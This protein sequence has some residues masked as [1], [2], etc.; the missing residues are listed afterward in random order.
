MSRWVI[1]GIRSHGVEVES[2]N[3]ERLLRDHKPIHE[4]SFTNREQKSLYSLP[5]AKRVAFDLSMKYVASVCAKD[6]I[7]ANTSF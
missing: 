1:K 4:M 7:I 3:M 6:R 5:T 2:H